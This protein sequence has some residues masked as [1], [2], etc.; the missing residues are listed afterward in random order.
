MDTSSKCTIICAKKRYTL[1]DRAENEIEKKS[2]KIDWI[3]SGSPPLGAERDRGVSADAASSTR[4]LRHLFRSG[5]SDSSDQHGG[6]LPGAARHHVAGPAR[7]GGRK[8]GRPGH[9]LHSDR[10]PRHHGTSKKKLSF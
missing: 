3:A 1:A 2:W 5:L 6:L 4:L 7:S 10:P 9:R 8:S